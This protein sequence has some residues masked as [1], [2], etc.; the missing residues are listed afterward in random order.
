MSNWRFI[1]GA[2]VAICI[3]VLIIV[4]GAMFGKVEDGGEIPERK[5]GKILVQTECPQNY[6]SRPL[7][8]V[9]MDGFR[10]DYLTRNLTPTLQEFA[11]EGV[12]A[13]YMV[14]S[15]PTLTFPNH[16][17]I[18]TGLYPESH[19]I[20]RNNFFD[21]VFKETFSYKN[22]HMTEG[23]WW[24]G[25]PIWNT[26]NKQGKKSA[27]Y[28]WPG[29]DAFIEDGQPTYWMKYDGTKPYNARIEQVVDW[30]M[31]PEEERPHWITLYFSEPDYTGHAYGP[32]SEELN[33]ELRMMDYYFST[34]LEGLVEKNIL[35][36]VNIILLSDHGLAQGDKILS[37]M[38]YVHDIKEHASFKGGAS[39][40]ISLKQQ[41][42]EAALE[43]MRQLS[44][45]REEMRVYDPKGLPKRVHFSYNR[46]IEDLIIDV[47]PGYALNLKPMDWVMDGVHGYDNIFPEMNTIFMARGPDF[48]S[49]LKVKPFQN[50]E[51]YNLM[52]HL[53]G[54]IPAKNNG[55]WGALHHMLRTPPEVPQIVEHEKP[56]VLRYPNSSL[57][58]YAGDSGCEGD[59]TILEPWMP[60]LDLTKEQEEKIETYHAPWGIPTI[61][62][63][64]VN[65]SILYH[66]DRITGYSSAIQIPLWTSF[67]VYPYQ[68]DNF[69]N[70]LGGSRWSS[71]ARLQP[72]MT[73]TCTA[74]S[75]LKRLNFSMLPLFPSAFSRNHTEG[76]DTSH[77]ISN[78]I[79]VSQDV[80]DRWQGLLSTLAPAW[81]E[82]QGP[83][84][85]VLGP[86]FDYDSNSHPD[87]F[88]AF[89]KKPAVPTD[90]FCVLTRCQAEVRTLDRCPFEE[91][92]S[93]AFIFHQDQP[94]SN[95]LSLGEFAL[96]FTS[97]VKDVEL[98]TG[99]TLFPKVPFETR[100]H[101]ILRIHPQ[102]WP[103]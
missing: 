42:K 102:L 68:I 37:V 91:L 20:I 22:N 39:G 67:T 99:L 30:L 9:S 52:C 41:S 94:I 77:L 31:L 59:A 78:A 27:T 24:G 61:N 60:S 80:R 29:S 17:S 55:T 98:V 7:L 58:S 103:L 23:R 26:L 74:Y 5:V 100:V 65:V 70:N 2:I 62:N 38:D 64:V 54:V 44:C 87:N 85:F 32:N 6:G 51:V 75:V 69:R 53:T 56:P 15:Y 57:G 50:I 92:D 86:V 82:S 89:S 66:M 101:Q 71:D 19:G 48:Q 25:E 40:K 34:L 33:D 81:I 88:S 47:D 95:C 11:D 49:N 35:N 16:Y 73:P 18:V 79:P 97:R 3:I 13:E 1:V 72:D 36:C 8:V 14:P 28:F 84:N 83:L 10:A 90:L 63:S 93:I 96:K 43:I 4:L 21:P 46:R 76:W 12:S 45:R